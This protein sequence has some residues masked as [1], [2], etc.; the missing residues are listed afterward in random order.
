MYAPLALNLPKKTIST[1]PVNEGGGGGSSHSK[2]KVGTVS[3]SAVGGVVFI[4]LAIGILFYRC[5]QANRRRIKDHTNEK[6]L[7]SLSG[8][9]FGSKKG[10]KSPPKHILEGTYIIEPFTHHGTEPRQ[11][12]S[13]CKISVLPVHKGIF[14]PGRI[15][16]VHCHQL[17]SSAPVVPLPREPTL[18]NSDLNNTAANNSSVVESSVTDTGISEISSSDAVADL[19][20]E[21]ENL[22]RVVEDIR[23]LRV[24]YESPPEYQVE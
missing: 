2:L 3:A 21:M 10:K 19:R 14:P 9:L 18:N 1:A 20:G 23:M 15:S 13:E 11:S 17:A 4:I 6:T 12:G 22:R 8:P 24:V 5:R 7:G 16:L